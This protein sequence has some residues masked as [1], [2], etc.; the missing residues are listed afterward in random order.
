MTTR[1][2]VNTSPEPFS[3]VAVSLVEDGFVVFMLWLSATHPVIFA[4]ALIV[5]LVLAVVLVV[6]LIKFLRIA[7]RRLND[8]FAG[9][10]LAPRKLETLMFKKILIA[11]RG[12]IACRVA[13]TARRMGVKT[14]A[15]Y[16][17]AD[18]NAKHVARLRRGG[19]HRRQRAEGQLP[20]LGAHHRSGQG[21]RRRRR[22]IRATAS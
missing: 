21:H 10:A 2:A 6:V 5:T 12:E 20:A 8:F 19:A 18:V 9:G 22:C 11:N 15:V 1:A 7:L 13:A 4:V 16:S 17:D 3:N 14:V